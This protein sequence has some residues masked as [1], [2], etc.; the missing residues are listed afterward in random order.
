MK[1]ALLLVLVLAGVGFGLFQSYSQEQV[2]EFNDALVDLLAE[3]QQPFEPFWEALLPWTSGEKVDPAQLEDLL[4]KI[5]SSHNTAMNELAALE[6]PGKALCDDYFAAVR[7][8][9]TIDGELIVA[10]RD[11]VDYVGSHNPAKS[12]A[13]LNYISEL[14]DPLNERQELAFTRAQ[15][16]QA[17]LAKKHDFELQ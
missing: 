13:D 16:V 3:S 6:I 1:K 5:E 2:V 14:V 17:D 9:I 11:L 7:D 12:E 4:T 10:Y 15:E 8:Y